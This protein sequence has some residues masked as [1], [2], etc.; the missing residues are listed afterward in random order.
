MKTAFLKCVEYGCLPSARWYCT[1]L[2]NET[3]D[4]FY[5]DN[6]IN[7][8][9][10]YYTKINEALGDIQSSRMTSHYKVQDGL[11]C[12]EYDNSIKVYVNYT[13]KAVTINGIKIPSM[14]CVKI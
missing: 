7:D 5:Y 9:V 14:D 10:N 13:D 4:K 6:N 2:D 12:T 1:K 3:D 8:M 11:Y